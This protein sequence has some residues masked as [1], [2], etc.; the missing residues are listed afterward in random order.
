MNMNQEPIVS[1]NIALLLGHDAPKEKRFIVWSRAIGER[2][3]SDIELNREDMFAHVSLYNVRL[4]AKNLPEMEQRLEAFAAELT[5]FNLQFRH[6]SRVSEYVFVDAEIDDMLRGLHERLITTLNDLREGEMYPGAL[7]VPGLSERQAANIREVGM[8]LSR[9]DF[10]PH[11]TVA[12]TSTEGEA[13]GALAILPQHFQVKT[14]VPALHL[15]ET[16]A[17]GTC[18]RILQKFTLGNA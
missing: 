7:D 15:V 14:M 8:R 4:P 10:Q 9:E 16:G 12:H 18:K 13:E 11:V 6:T 5:P 17:W 2:I 1:R 3:G